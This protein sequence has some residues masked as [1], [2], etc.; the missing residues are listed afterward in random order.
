VNSVQSFFENKFKE[1]MSEWESTLLK[2]LKIT[3]LGNKTKKEMINGQLWPTLS[4]S[5]LSQIHVTPELNWK[6][7]STT[8]IKLLADL[9]SSLAEDLNAGV[10]NFFFLSHELDETKWQMI[11]SIL[12]TYHTPSEIEVFILGQHKFSS[13]SFKVIN[14]IITGY[15]SH[16]A[17]GDAI[18]ELALIAK[19]VIESDENE[20]FVGVYVD[21]AFFQNIAKIRAIRLITSKILEDSGREGRV[22]V[23]ALTS[24]EGWTL[25]ERYSNMLRNETGVASAYIAGADHIQSTGYN[26]LFELESEVYS[27]DEHFL[28]SRRMA[29]NTT[30][31]LALE[32]MLG[33]VQD[34]AFGSYHLENLTNYLCEESW[35]VMQRMLSGEDVSPEINKAK[36]KKLQM[37][38]TRK[39][40][41][42]GINDYP[43]AKE[44]LGIE[45]KKTNFFRPSRVFEE[46]RLQMEKS[47]K[48]KV[49]IALFGDY[50]GLN[51]RL[52]F[53]KNYFEL[54][55]LEVI[56]LGTSEFDFEKFKKDL[57]LRHEEIMVLCASDEH[58]PMIQEAVPLIK[59]KNRFLAGKYEMNSCKNLFA[60][61]NIFENLQEIVQTFGG[62]K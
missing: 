41:L 56:D 38:K 59:T 32:S 42:S 33:I 43:D 39:R 23:V 18:H 20:L 2:E 7:A 21:S 58:Y 40:I 57:T 44:V 30:H 28:R 55:G 14:S 17:G 31:I 9:E 27:C 6:K 35:K 12:S 24:F 16:A 62:I 46:L 13:Q 54:L 53:V 34:A 45:L 47:K 11:E 15:E 51:A 8:Y 4:T 61:Q 48:P 19:K 10:K 1:N 5:R 50:A 3:D 37:I 52:N 36:E 25:F 22:R 26:A 29:R 49:F 60:G